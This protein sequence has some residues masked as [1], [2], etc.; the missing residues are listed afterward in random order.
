MGCNGLSNV[1]G[2]LTVPVIAP[3]V[4]AKTMHR[5]QLTQHADDIRL[6]LIV[7]NLNCNTLAIGTA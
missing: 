3:T 2:A 5:A 6:P 7:V 4:H 1:C